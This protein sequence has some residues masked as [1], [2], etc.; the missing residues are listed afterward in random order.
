VSGQVRS[1]RGELLTDYRAMLGTDTGLGTKGAQIKDGSF[2]FSGVAPGLYTLNITTSPNEAFEPGRRFEF[3]S[4][5]IEVGDENV[6]GLLITTGNGVT[7]SGRVVFEG[8]T[9]KNATA[10]A[11]VSANIFGGRFPF[12]RPSQQNNGAIANDG[13]FRITG[14]HGKV[15]FALWAHG[16][17]LKSVMLDGVDITDV[18]YDTNRGGT[19]RLEIVMTDEQQG[20]TGKVVDAR[21]SDGTFPLNDPA[22]W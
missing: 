14:V 8:A 22:S 3:A 16:W 19:D 5:P 1:A 9:A 18:P 6:D 17:Q 12:R 2:E 13:S 21:G 7:L 4:V 10:R 11:H 15:L 20:L